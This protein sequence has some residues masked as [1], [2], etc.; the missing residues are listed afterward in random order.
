VKRPG[1]MVRVPPRYQAI[2]VT[3]TI[4]C[5]SSYELLAAEVCQFISE[6]YQPHGGMV[7]EP[8]ANGNSDSFFYQPMLLSAKGA[9]A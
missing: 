8:A 1:R 3:Y 9:A 4:L 5:N 7:V 2:P 6:G